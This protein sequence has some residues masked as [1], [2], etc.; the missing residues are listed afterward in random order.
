MKDYLVDNKILY[1][2]QYSFLTYFSY[3]V[4]ISLVFYIIG[5]LNAKSEVLIRVNFYVKLFLGIF[6]M[7]R[8]S[9]RRINQIK[10]TD[11]DRKIAY[12]SGLYIIVISFSDLLASITEATREHVIKILEPYRNALFMN[13]NNHVFH[14][15]D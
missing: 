8:F 10:L 13:T 2:I 6:L 3:L 14:Y 4:Q 12:S 5:A 7:Y 15:H 1:D 9:S 11:L